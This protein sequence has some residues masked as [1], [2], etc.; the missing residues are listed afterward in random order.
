MDTFS[1]MLHKKSKILLEKTGENKEQLASEEQVP[2]KKLAL[3]IIALLVYFALWPIIGYVLSS[4]FFMIGLFI[5][6]KYPVIKGIVISAAVT[7]TINVVFKTVLQVPL[8][9]PEWL[10]WL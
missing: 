7:L 5:Y 4:L 3:L 1:I 6:Y 10:S 8:P 9:A 2:L